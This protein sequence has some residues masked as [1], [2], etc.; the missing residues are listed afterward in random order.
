MAD[1]T[2]T[3]T[4]SSL[5]YQ[6][7]LRTSHTGMALSKEGSLQLL[8]TELGP[9]QEDAFTNF[10][11]QAA[12]DVLKLFISRQGDVSGVPYEKTSTQIIYRF[13]ENPESLTQADALKAVMAE[14][15][16]NAIYTKV[17]ELWFGLKANA[18]Q[19]AL[20]IKEYAV[21]SAHIMGN[22]YRLHD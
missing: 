17:T 21:L 10:L 9:D 12:V 18:E 19:L 5:S 4:I 1:V 14:D 13:R 15:V 20:L 22:L 16:K 2:I 11:D 3:I 6:A 8:S 7:W